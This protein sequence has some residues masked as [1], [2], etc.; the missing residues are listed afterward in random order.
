MSGSQIENRTAGAL[1]SLEAIIK[2]GFLGVELIKPATKLPVLRDEIGVLG[3]NPRNSIGGVL[4]AGIQ[5]GVSDESRG[6]FES[7]SKSVA[8]NGPYVNRRPD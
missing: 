1:E 4:G 7:N 2:S 8:H 3:K 5:L 6:E